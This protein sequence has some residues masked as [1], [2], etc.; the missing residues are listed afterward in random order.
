[1]RKRKLKIGLANCLNFIRDRFNRVT[2]CLKINLIELV[3]I[4]VVPCDMSLTFEQE[5]IKK[6]L[7][8]ILLIF[9]K[10]KIKIVK[11]N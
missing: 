1:M 8:N 3:M 6:V 11:I 2:N 4:D 7:K 10:F 9:E 5:T